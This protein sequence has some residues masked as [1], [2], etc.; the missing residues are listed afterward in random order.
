MLLIMMSYNCDITTENDINYDISHM[1][2]IENDITMKIVL[3]IIII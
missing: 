2:T 3:E 1:K